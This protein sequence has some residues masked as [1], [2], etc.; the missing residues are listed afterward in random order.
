MV[1]D[2]S[3]GQNLEPRMVIGNKSRKSGFSLIELMIVIAILSVVAVL[4]IPA[5]GDYV[6]RAKISAMINAVEVVKLAV[7]ESRITNG[8]L[9][10]IDPTDTVNTLKTLGISDPS[11]LSSAISS[12]QFVKK[13]DNDMAIVICG[14]TVG[15]GTQAIDTVDLYLTGAYFP[16]GMKWACMYE[17]NGKFVPGG[18]RTLFDEGTY[19]SLNSACVH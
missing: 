1:F 19:G 13:D 12:I 7:A 14:S 11:V 3:Y 15:Q 16:S 6:I 10:E 9:N 8:N 2:D 18:C 4:A 5:Y 17:G